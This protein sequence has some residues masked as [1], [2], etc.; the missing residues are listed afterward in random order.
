[1]GP[2]GPDGNTV[3]DGPSSGTGQAGGKAAKK[4][5]ALVKKPAKE[6]RVQAPRVAKEQK[7]GSGFWTVQQWLKLG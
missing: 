1:M 6:P 2:A 5:E 3:W 7:V 4:S